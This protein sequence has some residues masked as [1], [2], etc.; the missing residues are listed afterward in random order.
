MLYND[1]TGQFVPILV[2]IALG[3]GTDLGIQLAL[4]GGD[5]Q[6]VSWTQVGVSGALGSIGGGWWTGAFKHAKSSASWFKLS[7]KWKNVS[8]RVRNAQGTPKGYELHHWL[9]ERNSWMGKK[10]PDAIKNHP[11]N[12]KAVERTVHQQIHGN[13]K[14]QEAYNA[15]GRWLHGTPS[16]A[17]GTEI[18]IMTGIGGDLV[19]YGENE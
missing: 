3:A 10:V 14:S 1:P 2:G 11:W 17:K 15:Y 8:P 7:T 13:S 19:T 12:L 9:I 5:F 6:C 18:S 4:N 16:W